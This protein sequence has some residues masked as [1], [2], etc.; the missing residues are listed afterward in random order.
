M[1]PWNFNMKSL[2]Q[3]C[4]G[5]HR[6]VSESF[7]EKEHFSRLEDSVIWKTGRKLNFKGE[8]DINEERRNDLISAGYDIGYDP[9]TNISYVNFKYN[10][11]SSKIKHIDYHL[12]TQAI[13]KLGIWH[14]NTTDENRLYI[15]PMAFSTRPG[16]TV[17]T[18]NPRTGGN[19]HIRLSSATI[20]YFI[21]FF[22]GSVTRY[23]PY[24]FESILSDKDIWMIGEFLKT[25]PPQFMTILI[26]KLL[27][28]PMFGSRMQLKS[29]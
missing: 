11:S 19:D 17:Y 10:A 21:M 25:Q 1:G 28:T 13:N 26:S 27:S 16:E 6:T 24:M 18:L 3:N 12:H 2:F 7:K 8:L 14:Y 9:A 5:I 20:I 22:L 15:S 29:E 23:H 4:I